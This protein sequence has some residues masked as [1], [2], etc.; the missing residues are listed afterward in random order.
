MPIQPQISVSQDR[1]AQALLW[2][3]MG[4]E[5]ST[6]GT[7]RLPPAN[8]QLKLSSVMLNLDYVQM[9]NQLSVA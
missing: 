1:A 5:P 2:I 4:E 8:C 6:V 9:R 7:E 3:R